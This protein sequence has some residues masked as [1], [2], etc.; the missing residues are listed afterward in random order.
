MRLVFL[1]VQ[2]LIILARSKN[3]DERI[4]NNKKINTLLLHAE[5]ISNK[6]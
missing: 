3:A 2:L 1:N 5:I 4:I 6:H